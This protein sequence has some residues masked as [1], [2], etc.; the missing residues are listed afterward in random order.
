MF[1][2]VNAGNAPVMVEEHAA[3]AGGA[4]VYSR[5]IFSHLISLQGWQHKTHAAGK[6]EVPAAQAYWA[7]C[8][9]M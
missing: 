1:L 2:L 9:L 7:T 4:L 8:R 3:G 5:N 6:T